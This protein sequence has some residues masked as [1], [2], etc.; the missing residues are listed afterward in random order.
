MGYEYACSKCNF[1]FFSGYLPGENRCDAICTC[2]GQDFEIAASGNKMP[3]VGEVGKLLL[4]NQNISPTFKEDTA[5]RAPAVYRFSAEGFAWQ[6]ED[7]LC[8]NCNTRGSI[9]TEFQ[10]NTSC[11]QCQEGE[12]MNL[13]LIANFK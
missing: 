5:Q 8:M 2:C 12:I 4:K 3:S 9:V 7:L 11:P 6:T 13:S 1:H 10:A